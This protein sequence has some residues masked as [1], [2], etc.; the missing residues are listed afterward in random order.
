MEHLSYRLERD[1]D[2]TM[3]IR[4][5][6]EHGTISYTKSRKPVTDWLEEGEIVHP[7]SFNLDYHRTGGP[8]RIFTN[9]RKL[10]FKHGYL[11]RE[12]GPAIEDPNGNEYWYN[13]VPLTKIKF[14][15]KTK[16]LSV[17]KIIELFSDPTSIC[18]ENTLAISEALLKKDISQERIDKL[19]RSAQAAHNL[20][21]N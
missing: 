10:Y 11:H 1:I 20:I 14:I 2:G 15:L 17:T 7:G 9:G 3:L 13:G 18:E 6:D 8:A 21:D 5:E 12:D 4:F 19:I 16:K